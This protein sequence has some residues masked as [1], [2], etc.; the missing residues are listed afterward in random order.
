VNVL[1]CGIP[2][3]GHVLPLVPLAQACAGLGY[4]TSLATGPLMLDRLPVKTVRAFPPWS[5]SDAEAETKRRYPELSALPPEEGYRFAVEL[6]ADV[7]AEYFITGLDEV[8]DNAQPDVLVYEVMAVGAALAASRRGIPCVCVGI[9]QWSFFTELL[10][11]TAQ[12]R[13]GGGESEAMFACAYL[14]QFPPSMRSADVVRPRSD[15]SL[16]PMPASTADAHVPAWLLA[17]AHRQRVYLTLGTVAFGATPALEA[18]LDV[19]DELD[20]DILVSISPDGDPSVLKP[21]SE[22]VHVETF[23]DQAAVLRHVDV[24]VHH[25]GS[26]TMLSAMASGRPQVVMPQGADQFQNAAALPGTG[27]GVSVFPNSAQSALADAIHDALNDRSIQDAA[28]RMANEI[29]DMPSPT[30]VAARLPGL[31]HDLLS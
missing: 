19:L 25:G 5:L 28:K 21:R 10:H 13:H 7:A 29:E 2:G 20:V 11:R 8:L 3:Y 12:Q 31:V 14:D 18:A 30:S 1:L 24:V 22:R 17:P 4:D 16:R 15:Q 9:V 27:A 26:G 23:V 6:F